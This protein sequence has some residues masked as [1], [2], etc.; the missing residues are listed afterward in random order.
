M[1]PGV[2]IY[3]QRLAK[4]IGSRK[5]LTEEVVE[6]ELVA[7]AVLVPAAVPDGLWPAMAM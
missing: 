2:I 1:K 7:V 3:V 5:S 6:E 4:A